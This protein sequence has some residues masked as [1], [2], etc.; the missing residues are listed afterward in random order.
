M[1][2]G[3]SKEIFS[4]IN[5]FFVPPIPIFQLGIFYGGKSLWGVNT[6]KGATKYKV[7]VISKDCI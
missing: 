7:K 5:I 1:D 4:T 6:L 3:R 2:M